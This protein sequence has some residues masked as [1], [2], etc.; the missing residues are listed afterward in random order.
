MTIKIEISETLYHITPRGNE[1]K[2]M[3][4]NESGFSIFM[5]VLESICERYN[6]VI[7]IYSLMTNHYHLLIETPDANL[8]KDMRHLNG[9][10]T[11]S[12]NR[13]LRR[14]GH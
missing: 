9:V 1:R 2:P 4:R 5:D 13:V 7:H 10:N 3:F 11:Q 14:A 8:S 12:F 6:L